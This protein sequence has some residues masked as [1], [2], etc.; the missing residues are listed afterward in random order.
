MVALCIAECQSR[1]DSGRP[2][3]TRQLFSSLLATF[4]VRIIQPARLPQKLVQI[5]VQ[6]VVGGL[7]DHEQ[8]PVPTLQLLDLEVGKI[9][10]IL[11]G[12]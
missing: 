4:A 3:P 8:F 11:V 9:G 2:Q 5:V 1:V 12:G 10:M 7:Q 6:I